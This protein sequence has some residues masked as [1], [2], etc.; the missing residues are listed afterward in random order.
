MVAIIGIATLFTALVYVFYFHVLEAAG[1]TNLLLVTFLILVSAIMLG[2]LVLGKGLDP[3]H[4]A[5]MALTTS[6]GRG[7][8]IAGP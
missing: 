1:A 5:G 3:K 4:F 7:A 8:S 2:A 6:D